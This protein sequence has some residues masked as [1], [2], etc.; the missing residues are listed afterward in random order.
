MSHLVESMA[1]VGDMPW[2]QLGSRLEKGMP[3]VSGKSA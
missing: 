3:H 2:H 1:Y